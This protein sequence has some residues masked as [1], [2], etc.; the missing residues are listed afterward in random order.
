ML[1]KSGIPF[2]GIYGETEI[3]IQEGNRV[4][5]GSTVNIICSIDPRVSIFGINI[6]CV[7]G[8]SAF[9]LRICFLQDRREDLVP[10]HTYFLVSSIFIT[11]KLKFLYF[12]NYTT[13]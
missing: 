9:I 8:L 5:P 13:M 6:K 11:R 2:S 4:E 12:L 1:N 10:L 3:K 7:R